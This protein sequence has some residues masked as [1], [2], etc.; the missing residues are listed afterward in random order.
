[1]RSVIGAAVALGVLAGGALVYMGAAGEGNAASDVADTVVAP[2]VVET[3]ACTL[4]DTTFAAIEDATTGDVA[5]MKPWRTASER[6]LDIGDLA[7]EG[8]DGSP[9]TLND[10]GEGLKL[11]NLWATWCA[12]CRAEMPELDELHA[13]EGEDGFGVVA[14]NVDLGEADKPLAFWDEVGM[15]HAPF[16]RDPSL[17][18]FNA[19]KAAGI[20][21]GLP[22]TALVDEEGCVLAAM[23]GPAAWASPDARALVAA[24]RDT[25]AQGQ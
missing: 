16:Y 11:L 17:N 8:P 7:F 21:V 4:S 19:L 24:A 13:L 5:A 18:T 2:G 15:S 3:A 9:T 1:M 12:P 23:N 6:G 20:A 14:L 10:A 25:L 22:V